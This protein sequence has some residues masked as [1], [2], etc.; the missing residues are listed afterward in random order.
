MPD[1]PAP[2]SSRMQRWLHVAV[3]ILA[4]AGFLYL[5]VRNIPAA[6]IWRAI[7]H[8]NLSMLV[9]A[10]G[11][12]IVANVARALRWMA[13]FGGA[14]G[15]RF[16]PVFGSMTVGYLANNVLPARL[17]EVVRIYLVERTTGVDIGL[18]AATVVVERLVEAFM[19]LLAVVALSFY[20]P[21][22][23]ALRTA[24]PVAAGIL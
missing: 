3:G 14:E 20:A 10:V 15:I 8:A 1:I 7:E 9:A 18:A 17:G 24:L 6:H 16:R 4:S 13:L 2:Q 11:L 5:A 22:P 19:L 23:H 12:V 21:L